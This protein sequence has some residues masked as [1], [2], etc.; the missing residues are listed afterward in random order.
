MR[1]ACREPGA[2][3]ESAERQ[4]SVTR[5]AL[6]TGT[7][8]HARRDVHARRTFRY[9]VYMA[10][11]DLGE[12]PELDRTLRLFSHDRRNVFALHDRDYEGATLDLAELRAANGLPVPAT[13][14]LVTNLR[15]FGYVFN[16]V[17]FFL[18]Y[19][20]SG[21][22]TSVIAE[23]NN[24][25]GGRRRY[26]LGPAQ[27]IDPRAS[28]PLPAKPAG[29]PPSRASAP[30]PAKPAGF[31]P[32]SA[33]A[34]Q[35]AGFP[36]IH[37]P[38]V[39]FRH[40]RELFVSPFLHGDASYE[41]W[42]DAPLDSDQLAITMHVDTPAGDRVFVARIDGTR[43]TLT[44]RA[45]AATAIRYPLMTLQV[46]GLIHLEALRLRLRGVPYRRPDR[47]HRPITS[48]T[49]VVSAAHRSTAMK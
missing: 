32:S 25:Y 3:S 26:V 30:L 38:Q 48:P 49:S 11:I 4:L 19:D 28:A 40:V 12:L 29:F 36:P 20:A 16:P 10:S 44:D 39:G 21:A 35:P 47:D 33:S 45:L 23:V 6:Y 43:R 7:L 17:S 41:L 37:G 34:P 8:M 31:P 22:I 42:F 24:T 15:V 1:R 46:I 13:T 9:P 5:S 14:R 27:R 2:L 18:D